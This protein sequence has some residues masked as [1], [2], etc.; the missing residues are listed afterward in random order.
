VI[1]ELK[2][3]GL[4]LAIDDFGT[5]YSS[6]NYLRQFGVGKLKIDR[7]FIRDIAVNLDDAAIT[8]A[9]ISMLTKFKATISA[10]LWRLTKLPTNCAATIPNTSEHKQ[11]GD[12]RDR[13]RCKEC[14]SL[15]PLPLRFWRPLILSQFSSSATL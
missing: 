13:G 12:N 5:G 9:I 11:A 2:A 14:I 6:F 4:T 8:A 3:M 7:S 1:Q 15:W 10:S